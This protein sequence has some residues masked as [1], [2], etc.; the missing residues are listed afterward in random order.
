MFNLFTD[1]P[2]FT[3]GIGN[4]LGLSHFPGHDSHGSQ[5]RSKSRK[6]WYLPS[7]ERPRI[8]FR[9]DYFR[10]N[11]RSLRADLRHFTNWPYYR[12]LLFD[13]SIQDAGELGRIKK[14]GP[15]ATFIISLKLN[16]IAN[17]IDR[18]SSPC[19]KQQQNH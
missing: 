19:P 17:R 2:F 9:S 11:S 1:Y 14:G 8:C 5:P 12:Y 6:H 10:D 4:G 3:F 7:L 13:H 16:S 15:R 18:G